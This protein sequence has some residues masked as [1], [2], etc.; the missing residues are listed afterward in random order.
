MSFINY[1]IASVFY[2][3]TEDE[4]Y[5]EDDLFSCEEDDEEKESEENEEY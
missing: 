2:E 5:D 4:D 1:V 3:L